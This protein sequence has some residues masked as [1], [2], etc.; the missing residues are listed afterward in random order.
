MKR[1]YFFQYLWYSFKYYLYSVPF[2][3]HLEFKK[4]LIVLFWNTSYFAPDFNTEPKIKKS[5]WSLYY[6]IEVPVIWSSIKKASQSTAWPIFTIEHCYTESQVLIG[7]HFLYHSDA[8]WLISL[9]AISVLYI[10]FMFLF[11]TKS[12]SLLL[13]SVYMIYLYAHFISH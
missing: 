13:V 6:W 7:C 3:I 5:K 8:L 12:F 11:N 4:N 9:I 10:F 1:Y 2:I